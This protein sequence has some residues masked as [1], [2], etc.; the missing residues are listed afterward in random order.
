MTDAAPVTGRDALD[1]WDFRRRVAEIYREVRNGPPG[2]ATWRR[3][4]AG[5]DELFAHHPQSALD[6]A[7]RATYSGLRYFDFNPAWR[8]EVE[9][10]PLA[11]DEVSLTNSDA[12]STDFRN[13][14]E[15]TLELAG[16]SVSLTMYWLDGYAGGVFLPF[17]DASNGAETYGDGRYLLDTA[18]GADLGHRGARVVLDFNYAYHPSC[19]YDARWSC[20]LAPRANWLDIA[21]PAGERLPATGTT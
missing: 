6:P 5:R 16:R 21:V 3:W 4:R 19:V 18:K 8:F 13:F 14:G 1:L 11:V 10:E 20:P 17:R 12:G 7:E 9:V 15:V 2:E